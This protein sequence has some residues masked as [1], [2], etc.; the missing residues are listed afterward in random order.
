MSLKAKLD[1]QYRHKDSKNLVYVYQVDG[2]QAEKDAYRAAKGSRNVD[3][4]ETGN[5][6]FFLGEF[7]ANG[8]SRLIEPNIS[9]IITRNNVVV[10]DDK[11]AKAAY[12]AQVKNLM[13]EKEAAVRATANVFR[14]QPIGATVRQVAAAGEVKA[15][16]TP[17]ELLNNSKAE[18]GAE[19]ISGKPIVAEDAIA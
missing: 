5:P 17:E 1:S 12:Q 3:D 2:T 10:I 16:P 4:S 9:L 19:D 13:A 7:D 11:A 15:L 18:E 8:M 14:P 6:L